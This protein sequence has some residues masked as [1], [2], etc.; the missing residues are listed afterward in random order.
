MKLT[1][2]DKNVQSL[3]AKTV[4]HYP[5]LLKIVDAIHA[6]GAAA[7]LVGGAVRDLFLKIPIKDIDIEIHGITPEGVEKL[8]AAFGKVSLVGKIFGVYRVHG[9]DVDWSLPRS[10]QPGRKPVV[11]IDPQLA[12][13]TALRRRD[14]T[15][16]A[17]AISLKTYELIDP[18]DGLA[19]MRKKVLRTPDE[20]FFVEDPLRFYRV[21]Q[22]AARFEMEP[23]KALN[24]LCA[25]MSLKGV[26]KERISD[27]FE[28]MFLKAARP[29]LGIR[30]LEKINKLNDVL[31]EVAALVGVQQNPRWH[32]EGGVFEH[33]MQ[34]IDAAAQFN[35]DNE[36]TKLIFLLAALCHDL[37]KAVSTQ[38]VE[39]NWKSSGHA[40]ESVPLAK[41]VLVRITKNKDLIK[42]VCTI[43]RYHMHVLLFVSDNA[44]IAAYKRLARHLAPHISLE[45]LAQFALADLRGRNSKS[46][47]PLTTVDSAIKK[48]QAC[49]TK[50]MVLQRAEEP[51]LQ[52]R[53]LMKFVNPGPAMGKILKR[54]YELQIEED[55]KNK[56]TLRKRVLREFNILK[57]Q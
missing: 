52:G 49:A 38:L 40:Q 29:S 15:M 20:H 44:G 39:G 50:A 13:E 32:P 16:N 56:T 36:Q 19:D 23:D 31:P 53:D 11:T 28:K 17:M 2:I 7:Y 54:A 6:H 42:P 4:A 45:Q 33:T 41:R 5:N 37:G 26:S 46:E 24:K 9:L 43:I 57:I 1:K 10:D 35:Y 48:F 30:W 12:I 27:E 22:F 8:L 21:M 47:L 3:L 25:T 14:L 55:I 18:F 34:T 51:L